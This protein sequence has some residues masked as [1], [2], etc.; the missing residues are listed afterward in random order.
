MNTVAGTDGRSVLVTGASRG[1][2]SAVALAFAE[3]GDRVAVAGR[4][5]QAL[6]G[7]ADEC[8]S[9]GAC[10]MLVL[11]FDLADADAC[12]GAIARCEQEFGGVEVLVNNAGVAESAKFTETTLEQWRRMMTVDVEAPFVLTRAALPGM[13]GRGRGAVVNIG[14]VSSRI[15][16]P[17]VAAYTAAKHA[18]LG[19]TR[20]LAAEYAASGVTFN[21]VCP[22]YADTPMTRATVRN[23]V[24]RTGRSEAAATEN[25]LSPQGR[26]IDPAEVAA[27]CVLLGSEAG[28]GITGQA[29][30]VDGGRVQS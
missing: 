6:A 8:T 19:L 17:Y 15:G 10:S 3:R 2:G 21:C 30:N 22:Y 18:L 7:V 14:S 20:A 13:L 28:R 26:L 1:I 29:I 11:P 4:D 9:R 12:A 25:P 24:A 23:I 5:E 27:L 16:L